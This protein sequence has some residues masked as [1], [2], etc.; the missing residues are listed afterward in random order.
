M[1]QKVTFYPT[2]KIIQVTSTPV[3][4]NNEWVVDIDVKIDL[5]SDG[6]EDWK[7]DPTLN[8][9]KFPIRAVGGD[10]L[11]GSKSLGSTFFL[12][13]GWKI[14]PY[15]F[16]HT[17]RVNGNLY[18]EDGTSPYTT[19]DGAYTVQIIQSVSSL[20]D[21]TVQQLAEIEY[22]TFSGGVT[23][24]AINGVAGTAYPVGTPGTPVNNV[25]DA[26]DIADERGLNQF[27]VKGN[28]TISTIDFSDGHIFVGDSPILTNITIDPSTDVTNCEFWDAGIT[29]TLDGNNILRRCLVGDLTY[30]N[31]FLSECAL[32]GTVTLGGGVN[33]Q[34]FDCKSGTAGNGAP[35]INMG[36]SGQALGL[37]NYSGGIEITNK[38]GPEEV[39][40][41]LSAGKIV[42]DSTVTDGE[43]TLRGVGKLDDKSTG[44]TTVHNELL[45]GI[46]V[47]NV[48]YLVESLRETHRATGNI[49]YWDPYNGDDTY[50]GRTRI[51]SVKTFSQAQTLATD[52][53]HD[54]IICVPGNPTATT[55]VDET[56]EISKNW[57]MLRGPGND[58]VI[59]PSTTNANGSFVNLTGATGTQVSGF[60]IDGSLVA[61]DGI[62]MD[63]H[64]ADMSDLDIINI[65]GDGIH[66]Q[67][68]HDNN[69]ERVRLHN[70]TGTGIITEDCIHFTGN[71]IIID[72]AVTGIK[73][74]AATPGSGGEGDLN[75]ILFIDCTTAVDIGTNVEQTKIRE[76]CRYVS[77][78]NEIVDN[79]TNTHI[80]SDVSISS[81]FDEPLSNHTISGTLGD[82]LN[83]KALTVQKFLGLK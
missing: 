80:E 61:G 68:C 6:K 81:L 47:D 70:V 75:D 13:S 52:W 55:V 7:S 42:I 63:S 46:G 17:M 15:A 2:S 35:T 1:G 57:L 5:Y 14:K 29:G 25:S 33:A 18:S 69:I 4:D 21:S 53:G 23:I 36:G 71:D 12:E 27:F 79:G 19:V 54:V 67:D 64:D 38:T 40:M 11:P 73:A 59:K 48:R 49:W 50:D 45:N 77:C 76:N 41:D 26:H 3:I 39:A 65:D 8:K 51:T 44:T 30:F 60:M 82:W 9:L 56:I 66:T 28:L 34:L 78:T 43:F 62:R 74:I 37:R 72:N 83:K 31:G 32:A 10:A 22:S 16:S 20:V 58:F 24:D